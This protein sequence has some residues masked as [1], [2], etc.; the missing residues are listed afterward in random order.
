MF[1]DFLKNVIRWRGTLKNE[2][3]KSLYQSSHKYFFLLIY[4]LDLRIFVHEKQNLSQFASE[5]KHS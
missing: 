4:M 5:D 1:T 2:V 3:D